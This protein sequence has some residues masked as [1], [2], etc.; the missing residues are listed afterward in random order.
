[1][2]LACVIWFFYVLCDTYSRY[3]F[4]GSRFILS[5]TRVSFLHPKAERLAEEAI[6]VVCAGDNDL[7]LM[8]MAM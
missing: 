6:K 8:K 1:V 5:S 3:M 2:T 4:T 7:I